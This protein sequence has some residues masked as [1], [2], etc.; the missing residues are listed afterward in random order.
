MQTQLPQALP[1]SLRLT[2]SLYIGRQLQAY[3]LLLVAKLCTKQLLQENPQPFV[4]TYHYCSLSGINVHIVGLNMA[5]RFDRRYN[6]PHSS[7]IWLKVFVEEV[8][9]HSQCCT[10]LA[11]GNYGEY[12]TAA[13]E[14]MR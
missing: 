2:G 9:E 5:T 7:A 14:C 6:M 1:I 12:D 3:S 11:A 4:I 13:I 10:Q 8:Q